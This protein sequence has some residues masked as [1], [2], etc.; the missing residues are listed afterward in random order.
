MVYA[1]FLFL[2]LSASLPTWA[3]DDGIPKGHL[4]ATQF[5]QDCL[6]EDGIACG[7]LGALYA[8]GEL[9]NSQP[10]YERG[11]FYHNKACRLGAANRCLRAA[12]FAFK[13][14]GT[15]PS[16]DKALELLT[17]GCD[18]KDGESCNNLALI[19]IDAQFLGPTLIKTRPANVPEYVMYLFERACDYG[20]KH[21][22]KNVATLKARPRKR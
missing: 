5:Y 20:S 13:G 18:I 15:D 14:Q 3:Q 9:S 7:N 8:S 1:P 2:L 17:H 10:N 6:N 4:K 12:T 11:F 19:K 22:C 16:K 21:G